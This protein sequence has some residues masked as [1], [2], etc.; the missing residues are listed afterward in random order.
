MQEHVELLKQNHM[1]IPPHNP[2]PS[3]LIR[4][5]EKEPVAVT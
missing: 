3:I 5:E 4:N 1:E 2:N